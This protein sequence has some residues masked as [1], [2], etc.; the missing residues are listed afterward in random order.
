MPNE[1]KFP[2]ILAHG[3]AR[4]DVLLE[5]LKQKLK[6]PDSELGERFH[7][8]KDIKPHLETHGFTVFHPNQDFAGSVQLRSGQLKQRV[9]EALAETGAAKVH[10]IAH[11]M[12]GL[13]ARHMIVDL[14]M[15]DQVASLTTIGTPHRGTILADH[16]LSHGGVLLLEVLKRVTNVDGFE[17]LTIKSC[18]QF[19]R[20]A[21]DAEVKNSVVYQTYASAEDFRRIFAPLIPSWLFI[22][23]QEGRNDG[24]VPFSS[25]QWTEELIASDGQRK[26]I[27]R[28]EFPVPADHLNQVGWWDPQEAA[29]SVTSVFKQAATYEDRIK[30]VYLEIANS[31]A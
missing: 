11:S 21:E 31:V 15:A 23:E 5:V 14:G 1:P 17:D 6:L 25:Q 29:F 7:Y 3:I 13:D 28:R 20:R 4:F 8:F 9:D 27:V 19:N 2:I 22:R 18:E 10:I 30:D 16:V 24:L 12:G 26:K